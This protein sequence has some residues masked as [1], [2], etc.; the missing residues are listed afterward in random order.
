MLTLTIINTV[1]NIGLLAGF[2]YLYAYRPRGERGPQGERGMR[3][4]RGMIGFRGPDGPQGPPGPQG[5]QGNQGN[6]GERGERGEQGPVGNQAQLETLRN[7]LLGNGKFFE[8][9]CVSPGV[10]QYALM[11]NVDV[12]PELPVSISYTFISGPGVLFTSRCPFV[13]VDS[14]GNEVIRN[15]YCVVD[16]SR[17]LIINQDNETFMKD[18]LLMYTPTGT[19]DAGACGIVSVQPGFDPVRIR[20][21]GF[22]G[23][24]VEARIGSSYGHRELIPV[25]VSGNRHYQPVGGVVE[26]LEGKIT[27]SGFPLALADS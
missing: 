14:R 10:Y 9:T 24:V 22:V 15:F 5:P 27:S 19:Y 18:N 25:C 12:P 26:D 20:G 4:E 21:E 7:I 2:A 17:L 16:G 6:P 13:W 11:P 23:I 8:L 3:G 1:L